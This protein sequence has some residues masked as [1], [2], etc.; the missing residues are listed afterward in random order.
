MKLADF[1]KRGLKYS[2]KTIY[3][4]I[5]QFFL[6]EEAISDYAVELMEKG[7]DSEII[8]DL[9]WQVDSN[10]LD[11][12]L[13]DIKNSFFP[14]LKVEEIKQEE[15]KLRLI[16]L[17]DL[18]EKNLDEKELLEEITKFYDDH[19]YPEEMASF[20]PY[21]PQEFASTNQDMVNRFYDFLRSEKTKLI[22]EL[23]GNCEQIR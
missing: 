14:N 20:I 21:M 16:H 12:V 9:A 11:Q 4:G 13:S 8:C 5:T 15:R 6:T 19:D 22:S 1:R 18:K 17:T 2:W 3:V 23:K 7:D 10:D